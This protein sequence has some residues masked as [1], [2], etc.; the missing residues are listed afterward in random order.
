VNGYSEKQLIGSV[1][2]VLETATV[3]SKCSFVSVTETKIIQFINGQQNLVVSGCD[4]KC[5]GVNTTQLINLFMCGHYTIIFLH[6]LSDIHATGS[7]SFC[8]VCDQLLSLDFYL[9]LFCIS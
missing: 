5:L 6:S 8:G 7:A 9:T 3:S 1:H 2:G 4:L